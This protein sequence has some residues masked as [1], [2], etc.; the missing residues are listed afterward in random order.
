MRTILQDVDRVLASAWY[1]A[2]AVVHTQDNVKIRLEREGHRRPDSQDSWARTFIVA[3]RAGVAEAGVKPPPEPSPDPTPTPPPTTGRPAPAPFN[4]RGLALLEPTGGTEDIQKAKLA[5]FTY[6][7]LNLGFVGGGSWDTHRQ[8]AA[9]F[10][11]KVVPWKRILGVDDVHH[12]ER[13]RAAWGAAGAGHNLEA[14]AATTFPPANLAGACRGYDTAARVVIT[15]PWVQPVDW[16]PLERDGWTC[17]PE[18]FLNADARYLPA[19]LVA[20][21]HDVGLSRVVPM[22]G[23]GDWSDAPHFVPPSTYLSR[24]DGPF[25]VFPGDGK[26]ELYSQ[27]A[28]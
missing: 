8:R 12:V 27:W 18:A 19:D 1:R 10:G 3:V 20:H 22:F 5:G 21:A 9:L 28:R 14:E 15:E 24:W 4:G 17:M 16:S 11:M 23:W 13:T 6:L 25:S 2:W 7:L 26:E